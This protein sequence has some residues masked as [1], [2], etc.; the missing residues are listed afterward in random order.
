[1]KNIDV[2][3]L[4]I[5][6]LLTSTIFLGIAATGPNDKWDKNQQWEI[7]LASFEHSPGTFL[8][9]RDADGDIGVRKDWHDAAD[10]AEPFGLQ[11][12]NII[13]RKRVK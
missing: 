6:T 11:G 2:K 13:F 7:S 4:I 12:K 1:M 5:G 10:G 3:S 9:Q 8:Y